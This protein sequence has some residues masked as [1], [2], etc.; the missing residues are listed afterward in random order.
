MKKNKNL[1]NRKKALKKM[2]HY[3][4]ITALD[5]GGF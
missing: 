3:A 5:P 1:I 4:A 2:G